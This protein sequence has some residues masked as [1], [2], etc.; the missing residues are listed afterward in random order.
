MG[1]SDLSLSHGQE[2]DQS[3]PSQSFPLTA[4]GILAM[5]WGSTMNFSHEAQQDELGKTFTDTF[6]QMFADAGKNSPT[7]QAFMQ[8]L[9]MEIF[10]TLRSLG[11]IR[12][13]HVIY[14]DY[15]ADKLTR[16][17]QSLEQIGN[18]ASFSG[19]GLFSKIGSFVG[20]GSVA[21]LVLKFNLPQFY[22]PLFA[23]AGIGG[24][25][26]LTIG[27]AI[28]VSHTDDSWVTKLTSKNNEYWKTRFKPDVT[29][30]LLFLFRQ[31]E[32]LIK[33]YYPNANEIFEHDELL[34]MSE[35]DEKLVEAIIANEILPPDDL[36]WAP[37][38]IT[39]NQSATINQS[40]PTSKDNTSKA[41]D[42]NAQ[43]AP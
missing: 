5:C 22:I 20:V 7:D 34:N 12:E 21:E 27:V 23:A 15:Q 35:H 18:L 19:S 33:E 28:Y 16:R 38:I 14:L 11:F 26:L 41:G 29:H 30:Q 17:R 2:T 4:R 13:N 42:A 9:Q 1:E 10:G 39:S 8:N 31:I 24:A 25:A 43:V 3:K 6:L 32:S 37:Y 40:T 36:I